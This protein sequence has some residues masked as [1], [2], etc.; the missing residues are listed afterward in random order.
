[1]WKRKLY[2]W[3]RKLAI[4]A[5]IPVL[6]WT[7]SGIMHPMMSNF[8]P[9][10]AK[11]FIRP[12]EIPVERLT[13]DLDSALQLNGIQEMTNFRVVSF[14]GNTF[15]QV[16]L[17]NQDELVYL[18]C[19]NGHVL[20]NGDEQYAV[21]LAREF[22]GDQNSAV[23]GITVQHDF[24]IEYARIFRLK[25]AYR[26]AFKRDDGLRVFVETRSSRLGT[27]VNDSRAAFSWIFAQLHNWHFLNFNEYVRISV[28]LVFVLICFAAASSGIIVYGLL[29]KKKGNGLR[30]YHR[31]I[32]IVVSFALLLFGVSAAFHIVPKY[33]P[34]ERDQFHNDQRY[35]L[36][37]LNLELVEVMQ[38]ARALGKIT[39]LSLARM[40][41]TDYL[42]VAIV[43]NRAKQLHYFDLAKQTWLK[44]GDEQYAAYLAN[45]FSGYEAN[46]LESITPIT[47][48]GGE[49]GFVNK[50]LPVFKVQYQVANHERLYVET[51]TGKLGAKVTDS[52]AFAGF[53]FGYFHKY[54]FLDFAGKIF[55]DVVMVL[56]ALG[57][58]ITALLG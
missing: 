17:P 18:N 7:I 57:N 35:S 26:V 39:N 8:K 56:F 25:P 10:L 52:Q 54:H 40:D 49:Y 6:M 22:A 21:Y 33:Q 19:Q 24:S 46:Q 48:F 13:V 2:A 29:G 11:K 44:N 15:F 5:L 38:R 50:R 37:N 16:K 4:I 12:Q 27:A 34:D 9:D 45:K 32:G 53:M 14:D 23:A 28:I 30:K 3:H 20:A 31:S 41:G 36:A 47:K 58:F 42:Q 55:R 43:V 1:M 51:A